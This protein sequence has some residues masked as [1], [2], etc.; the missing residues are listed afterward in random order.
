SAKRESWKRLT[1][2]AKDGRQLSRLFKV[3]QGSKTC[4]VG[5]LG[6]GSPEEALDLLSTASFPGCSE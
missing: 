3:I 5:L 6:S 1:E 4:S 2:S